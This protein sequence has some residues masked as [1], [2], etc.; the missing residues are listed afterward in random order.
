VSLR[1]IVLL[2]STGS[3]GT[4]ALGDHGFMAHVLRKRETVVVNENVA[5]AVKKQRSHLLHGDEHLGNLYIEPDGRPGFL[6][7]QVKRAPWSQGVSY[8]MVG[9]LDSGDR[10]NWERGLLAHYL[11]RLAANGVKAP[12]FEHAWLSYRRDILYGFLVWVVNDSQYQS[13]IVNVA[14]TVRFGTAMLEHDTL[15]LLG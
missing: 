10:R 13:E 2:G 4:Q 12:S 1:E 9:G 15:G 3:I 8:F 7:W 5:D 6:D 11:D 14:N